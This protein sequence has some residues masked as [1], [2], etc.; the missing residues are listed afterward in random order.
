M[1]KRKFSHIV[2]GK[3]YTRVSNSEYIYVSLTNS[4]DGKWYVAAWHK[5]RAA[6]ETKAK[7]LTYLSK[8]H[9]TG[10]P[11][12]SLGRVELINNGN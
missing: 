4:Y 8:N 5:T 9:I 7:S 2:D 1:A 6:A 12:G 11:W 3:V 10:A